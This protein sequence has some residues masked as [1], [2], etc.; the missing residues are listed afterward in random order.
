LQYLSAL[1]TKTVPQSVIDNASLVAWHSI[2][3]EE[4]SFGKHCPNQQEQ[5]AM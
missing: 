2:C 5:S 3:G 1:R 4:F